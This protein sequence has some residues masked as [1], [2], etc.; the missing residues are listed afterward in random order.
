MPSLAAAIS[1][2]WI[3]ISLVGL[4]H[5]STGMISSDYST[6]MSDSCSTGRPAHLAPAK[7]M[8]VRMKHRLARI[9]AGVDHDTKA[10]VG[11]AQLLGQPRGYLKNFSDERT[12]ARFDIE[13]TGDMLARNN[14]HMRR[15][16]GLDIFKRNDLIV[17][18]DNVTFD[19]A[20]NN[21]AE[22]A[23]AHRYLQF[24]FSTNKKD[25]SFPAEPGKRA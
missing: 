9:G 19:L 3:A 21:S 1:N 20:V 10:G 11:D 17:A 6:T 23:I 5:S 25:Q 18:I 22:E 14:K 2:C 4:R 15:R 7:Q 12:V 8:V 13:N 24:N 16:P